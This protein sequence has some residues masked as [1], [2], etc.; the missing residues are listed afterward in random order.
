MKRRKTFLNRNLTLLLTGR[1]VSDIGSSIQMLIMP[2]FIIDI[3]GDAAMVGL[4]SFLSLVPI[5]L[6]Y[7][8]GGVFGDRLNRKWIMVTADLI[9]GILLLAL[10][11][12]SLMN[13]IS[14]ISLFGV[15][16]LV[17]LAYGFFD[18]ASKGLL[19]DLV[20]KENLAQ[21]NSKI[22][23]LRILSGIAAPLIAVSL[24]TAFG[25][26]LL[27]AINGVSFLISGVSESFI[28]YK[29]DHKDVKN[30]FKGVFKDLS[31]GVKF[32]VNHR[33]IKSMSFFFL[34]SFALIQP[35][36]AV[37]LP[38]FFRT[39]L[40]YTDSQ[41]G[42]IQVMLFVGALAGSILVGIACKSGRLK[43]PFE[44]GITSVFIFMLLFAAILYPPIVSDLGNN[45]IEYL[46][47]FTAITFSLYTAIM[48]FVV[49]I[50]TIIQKSTDE[51][52]MSRVFSIVGMISKGGMPLGALIYG[53]VLN[54]FPVHIVVS[55]AAVLL[56]ALSILFLSSKSI[57]MIKDVEEIKPETIGGQDDIRI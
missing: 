41:Y 5:L 39:N 48:F 11:F 31:R 38:L 21:T 22:A 16:I 37:I 53:V 36:F 14:W 44:I 49:P 1:I 56:T 47:L 4:F 20:P 18:P 40:A 52:Y 54:R 42:I 8:F 24:Y 34:V 15:Q 33:L 6:M 51:E 10:A 35:V 26:T 46:V 27:F 25:I 9:S 28:R 32:I 29:T 2:L 17:A 13:M 50:Q 45:S 7:P 23:S 19:P 3:G 57:Q 12:L 55:I 43:R 30:G